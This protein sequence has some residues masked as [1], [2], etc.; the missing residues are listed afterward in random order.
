MLKNKSPFTKIRKEIFM[1][2]DLSEK[3]YFYSTVYLDVKSYVSTYTFSDYLLKE[4][5][6]YEGCQHSHPDSQ[7]GWNNER[8][9]GPIPR[10]RFFLDG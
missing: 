10:S 8:K 7:C 3:N 9:K 4:N 6:C 5:L 2:G 1:N